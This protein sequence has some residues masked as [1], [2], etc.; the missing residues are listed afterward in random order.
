MALVIFF[1]SD[2]AKS[3]AEM[4]RVVE[5]GGSVASYAWDILGGGFPLEPI[6]VELR[7]MGFE[8]PLPPRSDVSRMDALLELWSRA[9]LD[10]IDTRVI[11]VQ[12]TFADFD[13]FWTT[14]LT[15][16]VGPF[17]ATAL[18]SL[19]VRAAEH[20]HVPEP[21]EGPYRGAKPE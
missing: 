9:G 19:R 12:R 3:V 1:V 5:S 11:T 15:S 13:D 20:G 2:P 21:D 6:R 4:V 14:T 7:A 17:V 10:A 8:P 16:S 18:S